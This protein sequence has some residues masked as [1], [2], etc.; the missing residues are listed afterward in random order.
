[1]IEE[2]KCQSASRDLVAQVFEDEDMIS[3]GDLEKGG[4]GVGP[5][6]GNLHSAID[7]TDLKK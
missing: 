2:R 1:M 4:G 5:A 6:P 3:T 7:Q